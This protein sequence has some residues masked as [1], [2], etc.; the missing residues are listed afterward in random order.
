[1]RLLLSVLALTVSLCTAVPSQAAAPASSTPQVAWLSAAGDADIEQAF[2]QA[3][4]NGK[5]VLVYWG[6]S[7]C[8]P[9]NQLK[10]TLFNRQDFI[11]RSRS[12]VAVTIDGDLP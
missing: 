1:M 11:E 2:A 9:C 12:F 8:P 4:S 7:W 3:K 5:P 10:A 6:A